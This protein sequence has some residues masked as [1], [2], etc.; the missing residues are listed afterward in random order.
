MHKPSEK[1]Q[2]KGCTI[3]LEKDAYG[4]SKQT[5]RAKL[6]TDIGHH[7]DQKGGDNGEIERSF[8]AKTGENL[9]T[10]LEIDEGDI[11]TED[12]AREAGDPA[13]HVAGVCDGQDPMKN[14]RPSCFVSKSQVSW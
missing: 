4:V 2:G 8:V 5:T 11:E 6:T 14:Q 10:F 9:D 1:D 12:V 3:V 7:E 13:E